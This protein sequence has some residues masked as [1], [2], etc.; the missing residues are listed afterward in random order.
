MPTILRP[1]ASVG[2]FVFDCELGNS[3]GDVRDVSSRR[4]ARGESIVDHSVLNPTGRMFTLV[5]RCSN[6]GQP[7]NIGRPSPT[8]PSTDLEA[9]VR[10]LGSSVI[11]ASTR[12]ADL[13]SSLRAQIEI[14]D[15]VQVVSKKF[16]KLSAIVTAWQA[17][18]GETDHFASTYQVTL[19]EIR[20]ASGLF[21][22]S[23]SAGASALNG[24]GN[25]TSLGPT[26][27]T[28]SEIAFTP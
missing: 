26:S 25:T 3:R 23:P 22:T 2:A 18:D 4:I 5:G 7:Q 11:G 14:G 21:F 27:T 1:L 15:E 28:T 19:L 16:G 20:R 6:L 8:P 9:L 24:S 12:L 13:E 17:S 10:G